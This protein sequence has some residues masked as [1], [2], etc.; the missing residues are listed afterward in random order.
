[1]KMKDMTG[2]PGYKFAMT[3]SALDC[4]GCGSCANVCPGMKGNKALEMKGLEES[5]GEQ[6]MFDYAQTLPVKEDVIAK[7]KRT[8]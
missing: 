3:I 2:M 1:M 7:F 6:A 8:R 4:T 5:L